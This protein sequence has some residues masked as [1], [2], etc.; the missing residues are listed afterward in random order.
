MT[1]L[2]AKMHADELEI[3]SSLVRRLLL[4]QFPCWADLPLKRVL[5][6]GTDNALYRLGSDMVVRLPRIGWAAKNVDKEYAW[7]PKLAP[8][9]PIPIPAPL[10]KG[11]PAEGYPWP[12]A[13]YQW[14]EGKNPTVGH[15]PDPAALTV[16]LAAFIL[17]LHKIDLPDGPPS[18][19]GMP[20]AEKENDTSKAIRELDGMID[21]Q[22]VTRAW[23]HALQFPQWSKPPVWV[24]GDLSPGN[25]LMENNK[26]SAVID[27]GNLGIGDPACDLI[28]AWNLLPAHTR[29]T[30]RSVLRVDEATW[31][32][33][34]GW[35]L[36]NALIALPYYKDTNPVL[37]NNARHVI[38]EIIEEDR[39]R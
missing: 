10:N 9:L 12:W 38:Q 13:V 19:R 25:L 32:R 29:E 31:G 17:A 22:A 33:G 7:L 28:I 2:N 6:A 11:M 14:L 26:L 30:F 34:R 23:N 39:R 35:A 18:E 24:H 21:V 3:D 37:A 36:S 4:G 16:E 1:Q 27:F 15:I 8:F 5:S 20:L